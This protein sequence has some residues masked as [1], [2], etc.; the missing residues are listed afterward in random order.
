MR[1]L[2]VF[3]LIILFA[4][5]L[6]YFGQQMNE[7]TLSFHLLRNE[8]GYSEYVPFVGAP[9]GGIKSYRGADEDWIVERLKQ[10][11]HAEDIPFSK[12]HANSK[13]ILVVK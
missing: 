5:G 7:R 6:A 4:L 8:K 1:I 3:L 13:T 9:G 2:S 10:K 11:L 12:I